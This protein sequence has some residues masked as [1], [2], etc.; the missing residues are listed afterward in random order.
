M[1]IPSDEGIVLNYLKS[2][3]SAS[4]KEIA[5]GTGYG[6]DKLEPI[7]YN[8]ARNDRVSFAAIDKRAE[9]RIERDPSISKTG[10]Y[11]QY[12]LKHGSISYDEAN[13]LYPGATRVATSSVLSEMKKKKVLEEGT[14]GRLVKGPNFVTFKSRRHRKALPVAT[15]VIAEADTTPLPYRLSDLPPKESGIPA[16]E[17]K[18]AEKIMS[19]I[20]A[21]SGTTEIAKIISYLSGSHTD[22]SIR[23][24]MA[25]LK[26]LGKLE[27]PKRGLYKATDKAMAEYRAVFDSPPKLP[28][29][30]KVEKEVDESG[31]YGKGNGRSAK[32][33]LLLLLGDREKLA[34]RAINDGLKGFAIGGIGVQLW[35]M[36]KD[37]LATQEKG[38][39]CGEYKLTEAGLIAYRSIRK[40]ADAQ[41]A[42]DED[43]DAGINYSIRPTPAAS[44]AAP[45]A[46]QP[47]INPAIENALEKYK[48]DPRSSLI[49]RILN[50][51]D[52]QQGFAVDAQQV[53]QSLRTDEARIASLMTELASTGYL[54][55]YRNHYTLPNDTRSEQSTREP[56]PPVS[57]VLL[58][59]TISV[60][61][62]QPKGERPAADAPA[63]EKTRY[64]LSAYEGKER[65][66]AEIILERLGEARPGFYLSTG[67]LGHYLDGID[68]ITVRNLLEQ[69]VNLGVVDKNEKGGWA[70]GSG[71]RA[72]KRAEPPS[73]P[74][75]MH[76]HQQTTSAPQT[77]KPPYAS[78][79]GFGV[80]LEIMPAN[81]SIK[82]EASNKTSTPEPAQKA[83]EPTGPKW[84]LIRAIHH[85]G[86]GS[87]IGL[88]ML[89]LNAS[90][91][92]MSP[93]QIAESVSE[94]A[95]EGYLSRSSNGFKISEKSAAHLGVD[96][97]EKTYTPAPLDTRPVAYTDRVIELYHTKGEGA[98]VNERVLLSIVSKEELRSLVTNGTVRLKKDGYGLTGS[99]KNKLNAKYGD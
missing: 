90:D 13:N 50:R 56:M 97:S 80:K 11:I 36:K 93:Q 74:A 40:T 94:L 21:G 86:K 16:A 45:T 96:R 29:F 91:I 81:T 89:N 68:S 32:E 5:E 44:D 39:K 12:V 28:D 46:A 99:G 73:A 42:Q 9:A 70:I 72:E 83:Y 43:A 62:P 76:A 66:D 2:Q 92:E 14:N 71:K 64:A 31:Y 17:G 38:K 49:R 27:S 60:R 67:Q 35:S 87:Y 98:F 52:A 48:K 33:N 37:G 57:E 85:Y 95:R 53:A 41:P 34:R 65:V 6:S 26:R 8:L 54:E 22:A 25:R 88:R 75:P 59:P 77:S 1:S 58:E 24:E 82:S 69:L 55:V 79:A 51:V 3:K 47:K 15:H 18:I 10:T 20:A 61:K 7:L 63:S 23:V 78:G 30:Q 4:L 84:D 19:I